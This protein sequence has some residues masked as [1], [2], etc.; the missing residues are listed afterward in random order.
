[1]NRTLIGLGLLSLAACSRSPTRAQVEAAAAPV[2]PA[3]SEVAAPPPDVAPRPAANVARVSAIHETEAPPPSDLRLRIEKGEDGWAIVAERRGDVVSL[4]QGDERATG[5]DKASLELAPAS[6]AVVVEATRG[7]SLETTRVVVHVAKTDG[8]TPP[9]FAAHLAE[10]PAAAGADQRD[11]HACR[12][13]EDGFGGFAVVCRVAT[14]ANVGSITGDD[15]RDGVFEAI[16][17]TQGATTLA[18]LDLDLGD[19]LVVSK[20]LAYNSHGRGVLVRAE[21]SRVPGED[22]PSLV[23]ASSGREQPVV[24]PIRHGC[25]LMRQVDPAF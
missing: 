7:K 2:A 5:V 1:M 24:R 4:R 23:V 17:R 3:A 19:E 16:A 13:H 22:H 9:A 18:R 10:A 6:K 20:A 25:M 14:E 8:A 12:A 21:A 15:G 11:A